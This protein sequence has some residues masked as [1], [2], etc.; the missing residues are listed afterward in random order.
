MHAN[1]LTEDTLR[2]LSE[3]EAVEPVVV[4]L[5]LNLDPSEF[6]TEPARTSQITSLLS[7]LDALLDDSELSHDAKEALKADR[8][9]L[10]SFLREDLDA[11]GA[12][13]LAVYSSQALDLFEA[14]KLAEPIE[15]SVHVDLR[16]I[17][18]PVIGH[19][20]EGNWAVLLVTRDSGRIFR[21]G[22]TGIREIREV[23]S[24]VK[25]QH[26]AGGWSQARYER[27][28]DQE[29]EWHLETVTELLF[30]QFKRR[31]F[32]HLVVGANNESLRPML[33]SETH[34]Y[35]RER[36]RGWIDIDE[37]LASEDEV[38]AAVRGVM[39][40]H[41]AGQE[42]A[43][44][45]RY[46]AEAARGEKA[47]TSLADVLAALVEQRVETL[48]VREGA[49]AEGTKCIT[50]GWMGTAGVVDCPVDGT[51]LD[52][53]ENIVEPAIQAAIGQ[54]A[55]VHVIRRPDDHAPNEFDDPLAEAVGAILRY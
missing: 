21:G 3:I 7:D 48:L 22:P 24:D 40:E 19:E 12:E 34:S 37:D 55:D 6:A 27:G 35:L 50:C 33:E 46:E 23:H 39:D 16:P 38:F 15:P 4:S 51:R 17:L 54:S 32:E 18:E 29:V 45:E 47:A 28:V 53:I 10:E 43:L 1:E 26:K 5:F 31:P 42:S 41:L 20:D 8:Q 25:N 44:F 11:S 49:E 13:G 9:R 30:R 2:S 14:I 36:V 52:R